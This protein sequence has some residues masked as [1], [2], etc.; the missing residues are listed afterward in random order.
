MIRSAIV[1]AA[2][3]G[4]RMKSKRHKVLHEVCGK[5]MISHILDTLEEIGLSQVI[6][7]VGQQREKVMEAVSG[8]ADI[9]VQ[10]E[11]LGTGDAVRAAL[12][13]VRPDA[14]SVV[15]LYGDA[16][17]IRAGTLNKLF[18]QREEAGAAVGILTADVDDPTGLG[19]VFVDEAGFVSR[20]VEEKDATPEERLHTVVNTGMYVYDAG[21]LRESVQQ[22]RPD[23]AQHEYYLTDT[24]AILRHG[25]QPAIPVVVD[26]V[27]EIASVNDRLQLARVEQLCRRRIVEHWL[28]EGVTMVDPDSTYI[29]ANVRLS[30]D[31]TLLPG[32]ILMGDTSI[33]AFSVVGPNARLTNVTVGERATVQYSVAV[34]SRIG[35]DSQV[36]PFAYLRPGSD[37]GKRVKVGDFVEVKNSRIGDDTKVSHLTYVG[38]ADIGAD[39]NVG[40]GVITVNYDGERKHRTVVGD[41]SFVGSNVNLIAPVNVGEGSYIV[42]GTT[43]TEDVG[44]DAFVIGRVP[45][46]TKPNYVRAWK[47]KKKQANTSEGGDSRGH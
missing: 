13:Q 24:I 14:E 30:S 2:G 47:A 29:D 18:A 32:T 39:V 37:V 34:D 35:D 26:D 9:A 19:R 38:D 15:V 36:G 6:V 43:V 42:A 17:L 22:L 44:D 33:G 20:I 41:H 31:V 27:D 46:V 10:E 25:G 8:R 23:N 1:L 11:Q 16:P 45:Q 21:A 5:P 3:H 12:S 28:R 7:V 4:S 40:C